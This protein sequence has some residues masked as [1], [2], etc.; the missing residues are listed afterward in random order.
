MTDPDQTSD[1][2]PDAP[3]L[4]DLATKLVEHAFPD[5]PQTPQEKKKAGRKG[6]RLFYKSLD[7]R[8]AAE[9]A[10]EVEKRRQR[11]IKRA[12][13]EIPVPHARKARAFEAPPLDEILADA[14][15]QAVACG[16]TVKA[17]CDLH[18]VSYNVFSH[19]RAART[20]DGLRLNT[21]IS[22][23]REDSADVMADEIIAIADAVKHSKDH[24]EVAAARLRCD[25]RRW[26]AS[27]LKP[28]E[29]GDRVEA[30]LSGYDG[31]P[32]SIQVD[33]ARRA[34]AFAIFIARHGDKGIDALNEITR[35]SAM[36]LA[37]P[38]VIEPA[39]LKEIETEALE[40]AD[41]AS[42]PQ[43]PA[44]ENQR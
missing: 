17:A 33:D 18:S 22:R 21:R 23:A 25:V 41:E 9:Y 5:Q 16:A 14:I 34:K 31:G 36:K 10:R 39:A 12:R 20:E 27:K 44:T 8:E 26:C 42:P 30:R 15:V 3:S 43:P 6:P 40:I 2:D 4:G 38:S 29:Y 19:W 28:K 1:P 11:A 24:A 7:D 13:R 37:S 35:R 32:I